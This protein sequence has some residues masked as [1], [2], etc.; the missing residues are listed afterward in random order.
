MTSGAAEIELLDVERED[1][2]IYVSASLILDAPVPLVF[3][4]LSDYEHFAELSTRFQESR[5][6]EPAANGQPRIYTKIEG[7]IW[8]FCRTVQRYAQLELIPYVSITAT[9]EP[10]ESDVRY[11]VESWEFTTVGKVTR[12]SYTHE[13]EPKFWVPPIVGLWAIKSV[14][15]KDALESAQRIELLALGIDDKDIQSE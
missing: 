14:L 11:G 2:R 5:F 3:Q 10:T 7:C 9:V 4:A 1:G 12:V 15:N 6:L 8:F 13:M